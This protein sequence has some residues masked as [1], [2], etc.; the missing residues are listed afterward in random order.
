MSASDYVVLAVVAGLV[1]AACVVMRRR[2]KK[3]KCLG[4]GGNCTS[5]AARSLCGSEKNK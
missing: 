4:C 2:K 1:V 3:G 5:C